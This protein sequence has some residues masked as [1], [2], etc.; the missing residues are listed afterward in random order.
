[1]SLDD[2][3]IRTLYKKFLGIP[4]TGLG[5]GQL[6]DNEYTVDAAPFVYQYKIFSQSIPSTAPD[7]SSTKIS[8]IDSTNTTT[9]YY[10]IPIN[11]AQKYIKKY[12]NLTLSSLKGIP[13]TYAYADE[14]TGG[15]NLL[16]R[17]IKPSADPVNNTYAISVTANGQPIFISDY[18]LDADAGVLRI[19]KP[20]NGPVRITFWRY[21]G[22]LGNESPLTAVGT[23]YG[24]YLYYDPSKSDR[25]RWQ[26]GG[27]NAIQIG[28]NSGRYA[29][30]NR[31]GSIAIG[32]AA[33]NTSQ[34]SFSIAIGDNAGYS[35]QQSLAIA[36]GQYAGQTSQ[37]TKAIAIGHQAG[38]SQ[39][40]TYSI[41][42]GEAAGAFSQKSKAIAIGNEAGKQSQ[43]I[44]SICI[45]NLAGTGI[46]GDPITSQADNSII[47]NASGKQFIGDKSGFYVR[48]IRD[49]SGGGNRIL[50]YDISSGEITCASGGSLGSGSGLPTA[51]YK[52]GS[53][54]YYDP[55]GSSGNNWIVDTSNVNLGENAGRYHNQKIQSIA[56]GKEAGYSNQENNSIAIGT[57]AAYT[58]QWFNSIAIGLFSGKENQSNDS[59]AIGTKAAEY[60]Q[61][62]NSI[63]IGYSAGNTRQSNY[64]IA[65][66]EFAGYSNQ[67]TAGIAIGSNAGHT[68][69]SN[70]SIAIGHAAGKENQNKSSIAIGN[71]AGE[72]NQSNFSIAMG[73][74]AGYSNQGAY[75]IAIGHKAGYSNQSN[76]SIVI[77]ASDME[78]NTNNGSG[79]YINPIREALFVT[80]MKSMYYNPTTKEVTYD[81]SG[82]SAGIEL[83]GTVQTFDFANSDKKILY[84]DARTKSLEYTNKGIQVYTETRNDSIKLLSIMNYDLCN[85]TLANLIEGYI[86]GNRSNQY[87]ITFGGNV[88]ANDDSLNGGIRFTRNT[89]SD[90]RINYIQP[91]HKKI[92]GTGAEL[93]FSR[94][95]S[96][97]G[98]YGVVFDLSNA[99]YGFNTEN[100]TH[101]VTINGTLGLLTPQ[102]NLGSNA[103]QTSQGELSIALGA[104][105]GQTSQNS[106][107]IAVGAGAGRSNQNI[108]SVAVGYD[109]GTTSQLNNS[110][111]VGYSAGKSNQGMFSVAI[112]DSSAEVAQGNGAISIGASAGEQSQALNAVAIGANAGRFNQGQ[113]A[114]AIGNNAGYSNQDNNTIVIN[115][116]GNELRTDGADSTYIAP[117]RQRLK[118]ALCKPLWW[119]PLTG[120]VFIEVA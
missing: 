22:T 102:L 4:N 11:D 20:H 23:N 82:V 112:G 16:K 74:N 115:A 58:S 17:A 60:N 103:G 40:Q 108:Y 44:N 9:D 78:I 31:G 35:N 3:I 15:N 39:Q 101:T 71:S 110:I 41:A 105:A 25:E 75:S 114:I 56:I 37:E 24:E 90:K 116:T 10:Q 19:F 107:S 54:L 77:N 49:I 81:T 72:I 92:G 38:Q 48:P 63:A 46:S 106:F 42:I 91:F 113:Y 5:Q 26:I 52:F 88:N 30:T 70:Y 104:F 79:L 100:L 87:N 8:L 14:S 96:G 43:G 119:D 99:R 47:I 83:T 59:I 32:F 117:I 21:E 36:M 34:N 6:L 65:I 29:Q 86:D 2:T 94:Y 118:H 97:V 62:N 7:L 85:N 57:S 64:S 76:N 12:T 93:H 66:G 80:D 13:S 98:E 55:S 67:S 95:F 50:Y 51:D 89:G 53:Y 73:F 68:S 33:G 27:S 120:E 111:A 61:K 45:G 1:M 109:A 69:Q 18:I 28:S 84:Y